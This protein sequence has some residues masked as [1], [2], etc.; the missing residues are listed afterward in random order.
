MVDTMDAG[1]RFGSV[2]SYTVL[3]LIDM[4]WLLPASDLL[5]CIVI[6]HLLI[7]YAS[8]SPGLLGVQL[9]WLQVVDYHLLIMHGNHF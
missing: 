2:L 9:S 7:A 6:L 4:L 8:S 1:A 3:C 5:S